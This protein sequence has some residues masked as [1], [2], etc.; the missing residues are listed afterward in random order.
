MLKCFN[1]IYWNK[2]QI[3]KTAKELERSL[4]KLFIFS[5]LNSVYTSLSYLFSHDWILFT[6]LSFIRF[7]VFHVQ[8]LKRLF[9]FWKLPGNEFYSLS[10]IKNASSINRRF[11][12]PRFEQ[13]EIDMKN[14]RHGFFSE[15]T[16]L[17]VRTR[18][19]P[20]S[21]GFWE[22]SGVFWTR[23]LQLRPAKFRLCKT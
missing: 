14:P 10:L 12:K 8:M 23:F 15:R 20:K 3:L 9:W 5:W 18:I 17:V 1:C 11:S 2:S 19:L 16:H 13:M 4:V 7:F 22:I 21:D 6:L